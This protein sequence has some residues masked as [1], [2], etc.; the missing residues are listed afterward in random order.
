V[1]VAP[2]FLSYLSVHLA[3][4]I[5]AVAWL[6]NSLLERLFSNPVPVG[7]TGRLVPPKSHGHGLVL[8]DGSSAR[9]KSSCAHVC[10]SKVAELAVQPSWGVS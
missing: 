5:P 1:D 6:E 9:A 3:A 4:A 7:S 10:D 2:Y 8:T